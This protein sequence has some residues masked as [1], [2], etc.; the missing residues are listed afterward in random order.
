MKEPKIKGKI[1]YVEDEVDAL[2]TMIEFLNIRGFAVIASCSCDEACKNLEKYKPDLILVDIKLI[3]QS[4]LDF[5]RHIRRQG[6]QTP[7]IVITAYQKEAAE[8]ILKD[9]NI[10][11][12]YIKP[13]SYAPVYNCITEILERI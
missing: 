4:G 9:L 10:N 5:I 11:A 7:V 6:C 13:I 3:D 2:C 8:N 12:C 1:M